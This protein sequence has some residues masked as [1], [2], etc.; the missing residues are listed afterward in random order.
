VKLNQKLVVFGLVAA[1]LG[2]AV[3]LVLSILP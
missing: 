1:F 2:T 3:A